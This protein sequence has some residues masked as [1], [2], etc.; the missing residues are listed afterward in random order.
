MNSVVPVVITSSTRI[1]GR[2]ESRVRSSWLMENF[3]GN[4][5][6]PLP[7]AQPAL[8]CFG[9][10]PDENSGGKGAAP[11]DLA[12]PPRRFGGL[13]LPSAEIA[14]LVKRQ[15]NRQTMLAIR[16][17]RKVPCHQRC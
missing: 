3:P 13:V 5:A 8:A 10:V 17:H 11:G 12:E 15:Q 2:P 9:L 14:M 16:N 6:A 7:A 4:I 1:T